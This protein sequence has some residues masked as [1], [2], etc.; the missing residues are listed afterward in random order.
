MK[1]SEKMGKCVV[2]VG[3]GGHCKSV[4]D[5]V[6]QLDNGLEIVITDVR[7]PKGMMIMGCPVAG[8]DDM[9]P[10]LYQEG[11]RQAFVTVGSIGDTSVRRRICEH[12]KKL[13]FELPSV[14]DPSALIAESARI[15]DGVFVGKR[16]VVNS[17]SVIGE[18][19]IINTGAIIEHE[20]RIGKFTHVAVG[21]TVCGGVEISDDVFVGANATIIQG[22]KIGRKCVIGAGSIVLSDVPEN[23][24]VKGVW[25][26]K[27]T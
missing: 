12:V 14:V 10:I 6:R 22:M 21:A 2:M 27:R 25:N 8:T 9:L 5:A 13:G 15:G 4:I 18:M 16:A 17:E 11:V 20:C 19:A 7:Y 1:Q 3:G 23:S 24:V 26:Q